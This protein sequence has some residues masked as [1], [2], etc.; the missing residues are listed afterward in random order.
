MEKRIVSVAII[1]VPGLCL[2]GSGRDSSLY[3]TASYAPV[4]RHLDDVYRPAH[5]LFDPR[6]DNEKTVPAKARISSR[7]VSFDGDIAHIIN[8]IQVCFIAAPLTR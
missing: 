6:L 2:V 3:Q 7:L 1:S 8:T 5:T 4:T